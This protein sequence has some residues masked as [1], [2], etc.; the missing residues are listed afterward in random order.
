MA[1]RNIQ[2]I[3]VTVGVLGFIVV[4]GILGVSIAILIKVNKD[5]SDNNNDN[6]QT[7]TTPSSA[8]FDCMN[9]STLPQATD[10]LSFDPVSLFGFIV[11]R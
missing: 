6:I 8:N 7:S 3:L 5:N 2:E 10:I 4:L 11:L 1:K 9:K